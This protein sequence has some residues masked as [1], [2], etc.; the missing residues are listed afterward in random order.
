MQAKQQELKFNEEQMKAKMDQM[1]ADVADTIASLTASGGGGGRYFRIFRLL[2]PNYIVKFG[3]IGFSG[4]YV[5]DKELD[6]ARESL[7]LA[8]DELVAL[9]E[10][11]EALQAELESQRKICDML[12]QLALNSGVVSASLPVVIDKDEGEGEDDQGD[13]AEKVADDV[14]VLKLT[15]SMGGGGAGGKGSNRRDNSGIVELPE[16]ILNIKRAIVKV[17]DIFLRGV[18]SFNKVFFK[19]GTN[20]WKSNRRDE[21]YDLYLDS[22]ED[23]YKNLHSNEL[24]NPLADSI[25][26]GKNQGT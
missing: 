26:N 10:A 19:Q 2:Y 14:V 20:L 1:A 9:A 3:V 22:C 13:S 24:R 5:S 16:V 21:C 7:D 15:P 18:S 6:Q 4:S 25:A 17:N 11:K 8:Q 12:R 23:T